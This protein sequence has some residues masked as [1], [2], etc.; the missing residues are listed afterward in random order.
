MIVISAGPFVTRL[1]HTCDMMVL[2]NKEILSKMSHKKYRL[3]LCFTFILTLVGLLLLASLTEPAVQAG[4]T[5]PSRSAPVPSTL[6]GDDGGSN[7]AD[8]PVG[9]YIQWPVQDVL[10]GT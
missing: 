6:P 5:L 3:I 9:T 1:L 2:R 4:P 10:A 8:Q 7:Q